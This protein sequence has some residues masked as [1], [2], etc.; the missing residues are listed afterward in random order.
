MLSVAG[1]SVGAGNSMLSF[2]KILESEVTPCLGIAKLDVKI[3]TNN[4][5]A[6]VQVLLS[7]KSVVFLTPPIVGCF[8]HQK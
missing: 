8:L 2:S 7:K 3:N 5:T 4:A 1:V 6:N